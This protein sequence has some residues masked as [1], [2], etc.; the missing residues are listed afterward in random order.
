MLATEVRK[1]RNEARWRVCAARE[2]GR[3]YPD[4]ELPTSLTP[5]VLHALANIV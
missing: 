2:V 3:D 5:G 4:V 1:K